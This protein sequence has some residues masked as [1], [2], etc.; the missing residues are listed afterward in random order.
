MAA[1][2]F[3]KTKVV[4]SHSTTKNQSGLHEIFTRNV[5]ICRQGETD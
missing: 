1:V 3:P 5:R 2:C 4:L